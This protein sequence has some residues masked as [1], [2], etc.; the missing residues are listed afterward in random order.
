[1]STSD[2]YKERIARAR[3]RT[4]DRFQ[5]VPLRLT[6]PHTLLSMDSERDSPGYSQRTSLEMA[7]DLPRDEER[8][9][10]A[11]PTDAAARPTSPQPS[12][13]EGDARRTWKPASPSG[14]G[15]EV[16]TITDERL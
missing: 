14:V 2:K 10:A 3:R 8:V 5:G 12:E 6:S 4:A 11:G 7:E 1:M 16:T 15:R 13:G 9:A